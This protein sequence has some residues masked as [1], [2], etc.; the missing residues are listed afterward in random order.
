MH[1]Y[2]ILARAHG[3][4][5]FSRAV[6]TIARE[7]R[8]DAESLISHGP[9]VRK[10]N[11]ENSYFYNFNRNQIRNFYLGPDILAVVNSALPGGVIF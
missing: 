11:W 4:P 1:F 9:S 7:K 8:D 3:L 2:G 10:G 5:F 6:A